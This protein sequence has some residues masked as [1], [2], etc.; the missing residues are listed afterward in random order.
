MQKLDLSTSEESVLKEALEADM[1]KNPK[2]TLE[3]NC[4]TKARD[5]LEEATGDVFSRF[6]SPLPS[7]LRSDVEKLGR[8]LETECRPKKDT[9]QPPPP[10][11]GRKKKAT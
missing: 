11:K 1:E 4:S 3:T 8:V 7:A 9:A 2:W 6:A 10:L 5:M